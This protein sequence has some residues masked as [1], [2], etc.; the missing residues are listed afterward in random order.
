[1]KKNHAA[2][3]E[4]VGPQSLVGYSRPL[5]IFRRSVVLVTR[6]TTRSRSSR[7]SGGS[8][9]ARS[10]VW[11]WK[12]G[13]GSRIGVA[14]LPTLLRG[15]PGAEEEAVYGP[16]RMSRATYRVVPARPDG[17]PRRPGGVL[18]G[19]RA[20]ARVAGVGGEGSGPRTQGERGGAGVGA[21][22]YRGDTAPAR[23]GTELTR[24]ACGGTGER[25]STGE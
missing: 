22:L 17:A 18:E 14:W 16:K 12:L 23:Q 21:R 1:M 19:A 25:A 8:K 3:A 6:P 4:F 13:H 9:M 7:R 20:G 10:V 2:P 5:S 24:E 15:C 11:E